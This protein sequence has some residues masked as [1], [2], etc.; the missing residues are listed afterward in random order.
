MKKFGLEIH[1]KSISGQKV[2]E[3]QWFHDVKP[4]KLENFKFNKNINLVNNECLLE[5]T[6]QNRV[7]PMHPTCLRCL[8]QKFMII[9]N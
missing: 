7:I 1:V 4:Y 9:E 6:I 3:I 8:K 2:L 5:T